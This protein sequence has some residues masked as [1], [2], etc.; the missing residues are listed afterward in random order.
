MADAVEIET[1]ASCRLADEYDAA[2][3]RGE[4]GKEGGSGSNQYATVPKENICSTVIDIGLTRKQVHED[5][6]CREGGAG[7]HVAWT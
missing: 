5:A 2:Q 4:V 1:Q 3:A 6:R 7:H